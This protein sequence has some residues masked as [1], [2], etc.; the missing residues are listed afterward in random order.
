[1]GADP[2]SS[3]E[4]LTVEAVRLDRHLDGLTELQGLR[5][6]VVRVDTPGCTQRALGGLIRLLRR[7]RPHIVCTFSP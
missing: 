1:G 2:A 3:T 5:I 7:D 4:P 6:S